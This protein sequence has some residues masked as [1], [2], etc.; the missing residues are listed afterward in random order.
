MKDSTATTTEPQA[1]EELLKKAQEA[2][3]GLFRM[4]FGNGSGDV[5]EQVT[6]RVVESQKRAFDMMRSFAH[7]WGDLAERGVDGPESWHRV[8][9]ETT[10]TMSNLSSGFDVKQLIDSWRTQGEQMMDMFRPWQAATGHGMPSA[11][12][13]WPF[14]QE[15]T[16][17]ISSPG[18][19]VTREY[20]SQINHLFG[21]WLE[22]Q[23]VD[24]EYK[25]TLLEAWTEAF[26]SMTERTSRM[27]REGK[28]FDHPREMM[29]LWVEV[30]DQI[31]TDLFHTETFSTLQAELLNAAHRIRKGRRS[32]AEQMLKSSDLP[33]KSDLEEA[34]RSIYLLR[35]E[36]RALQRKMEA[37][38]QERNGKG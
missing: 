5:V 2:M 32:L 30:A 26:R 25:R 29:D 12:Q 35:K 13:A 24:F 14:G 33:T 36:V 28:K 11:R 8:L 37:M 20:Q 22:Y 23:R 18:F 7:V 4:P 27:V 16:S 34:H 3:L 10:K 15:I 1:A 19:G 17:F 38:E 6:D 31:F 21:D 9:D